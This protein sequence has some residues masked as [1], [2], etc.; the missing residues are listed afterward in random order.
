MKSPGWNPFSTVKSECPFQK[1][2][3][4]IILLPIILQRFLSITWSNLK[5]NS[6]PVTTPRTSLPHWFVLSIPFVNQDFFLFLPWKHHATPPLHCNCI[7]FLQCFLT[8]NVPSGDMSNLLEVGLTVKVQR[9]ILWSWA[10]WY[11]RFSILLCELEQ[12]T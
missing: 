4:N 2:K 3:L 6:N 5:T 8:Q 1:R 7:L 11:P 9:S 10:A 12:V